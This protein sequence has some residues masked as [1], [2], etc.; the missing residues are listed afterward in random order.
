MVT[1]S[2]KVSLGTTMLAK[3]LPLVLVVPLFFNLQTFDF[4][5]AVN[6]DV[7]QF[8]YLLALGVVTTISFIEFRIAQGEKRGAESINIGMGLGIIF[9][10]VGLSFIVF[11]VA[12]DYQYTD[13]TTN[14]WISGFLGLAIFFLAIQAIREI[15]VGRKQLKQAGFL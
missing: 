1:P 11:V 13:A 15:T 2:G 10:V 9:T 4:L 8:S 7:T 12:T 5:P 14:Q 6:F 3:I